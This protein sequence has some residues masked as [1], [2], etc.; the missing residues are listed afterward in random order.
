MTSARIVL[1]VTPSQDSTVSGIKSGLEKVLSRHG[2]RLQLVY[3]PFE[4]RV[5]DIKALVDIWHPVGVVAAISDFDV[6]NLRLPTV[7]AAVEH[8][9]RR[10]DVLVNDSMAMG[11]LAADELCRLGD[12]SYGYVSHP[13]AFGWTRQRGAAFREAVSGRGGR[14]SSFCLRSLRLDDKSMVDDFKK[15]LSEMQKPC[16]IFAANDEIAA[17]TISVAR[18]LGLRVPDDVAVVGVDDNPAYVE[19]GQVSITSVVPDWEGMGRASGECLLKRI[20]GDVSNGLCQSVAPRGIVRRASTRRLMR[21]GNSLVRKAMAYIRDNACSGITS[22]DVIAHIGCSRSLANLRF[23]EATG[24]SILQAIHDE[25]FS[26]AVGL[27]AAGHGDVRKAA[28]LC[29][30]RSTAFFRREYKARTGRTFGGK[31]G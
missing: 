23:R 6:Q 31:G 28:A 17:L 2:I 10:H 15:F 22:S 24:K 30:Y 21:V 11:R 4:R 8:G 3:T 9:G 29:G 20:G 19:C 27:A 13:G 25:R 14:V 18:E 26:K 12:V 5:S 7:F 1:F 16:G